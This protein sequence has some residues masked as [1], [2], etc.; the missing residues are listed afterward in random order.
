MNF[1]IRLFFLFSD[2]P[3]SFDISFPL[4]SHLVITWSFVIMRLFVYAEK[5]I[6]SL[7]VTDDDDDGLVMK[8]RK[9]HETFVK[10]LAVSFSGRKHSE[11]FDDH[12]QSS[13]SFQ[14]DKSHIRVLS[15][16][17]IQKNKI[18]KFV[19]VNFVKL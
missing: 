19:V 14:R 1:P 5:T 7:N 13:F 17:F 4:P 18:F 15:F 16:V 10:K 2:M 9:F 12:F 3:K 11:L 8:S 6:L